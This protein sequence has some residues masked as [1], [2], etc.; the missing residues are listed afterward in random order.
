MNEDK[1]YQDF[2]RETTHKEVIHHLAHTSNTKAWYEE[3]KETSPVVFDK[4]IWSDYE[5]LPEKPIKDVTEYTLKI[6]QEQVTVYKYIEDLPLEPTKENNVFYNKDFINIIDKNG[7][8]VILKCNGEE[9]PFGLNK[10]FFDYNSGYLTFIEGKP[11]GWDGQ[12]T[13]SFYKYT[14]RTLKNTVIKRDGSVQ[15][16]D[17]YNPELKKD[18]VTKDYV[19]I[20]L[21]ATDE[22]VQKLIPPEPPTLE[23]TDIDF[24]VDGPIYTG[25]M[26]LNGDKVDQV[27]IEDEEITLR[28]KR[29]YNERENGKTSLY[30][31]GRV[32][33]TIDHLNP[34]SFGKLFV[35]YD[36]DFYKDDLNSKGFYEG[37]QLELKCKA[38]EFPP[39]I[40]LLSMAAPTLKFKFITEYPSGKKY[41]TK[42][43]II[44]VEDV[45]KE[46][47]FEFTR[48]YQ[49]KL[50]PNESLRWKNIS[51]V[52]TIT[53]GSLIDYSNLTS[54]T[55]NKYFVEEQKIAQ[56][57]FFND[58]TTVDVLPN[59]KGYG[60]VVNPKVPI[61]GSIEVPNNYYNEELPVGAKS[62]TLAQDLNDDWSDLY[63]IRIDT[64]SD[65][66]RRVYSGVVESK[67]AGAAWDPNKNLYGLRELQMVNNK[68]VWP[69][70]DY[71]KNGKDISWIKHWD[72]EG[73]IKPGPNYSIIDKKG[74]CYAT[75]EYE[76]PYANGIFITIPELTLVEPFRHF[77]VANMQIKVEGFTGWLDAMKPYDGIGK[78]RKDG[79]GCLVVPKC[80][81][82]TIYAT[83]GPDPIYGRVLV[84]IGIIYEDK[85]PFSTPTIKSNI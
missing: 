79:E 76:I 77:N 5:Y 28:T 63:P 38:N 31:N 81:D 55:L 26:V 35:V 43:I 67:P 60:I 36:D 21:N 41:S 48:D 85:V 78:V 40:N 45:P 14:G 54:T 68:W 19:D 71:S 23:G 24:S 84:R 72:T 33:T 8:N 56:L 9:V 27:V 50:M 25:N 61:S 74:K 10:W 51:G 18:V 17:D 49:I 15:M 53:A 80:I 7:Y 57:S 3:N 37:L 42:E 59:T 2:I 6:G 34:Q 4:D 30:V 52:P 32:Y 46:H 65:E 66:S 1:N 83:F 58:E 11:E 73:W 44:G 64:V 20:H 12:F 75:F 13:V 62:F 47:G 39:Y 70:V 16:A 69:E 29:F 82:N 22:V